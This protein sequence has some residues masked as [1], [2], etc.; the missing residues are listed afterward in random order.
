LAVGIRGGHHTLFGYR[1]PIAI[2]NCADQDRNGP[3]RA[4]DILQ[5]K[6]RVVVSVP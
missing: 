1:G 4:T 6:D 3:A 5:M 2:Q